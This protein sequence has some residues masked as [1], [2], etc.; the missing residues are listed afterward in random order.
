MI[1]FVIGRNKP[2]KVQIGTLDVNIKLQY[3]IVDY[4]MSIQKNNPDNPGIY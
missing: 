3:M 2:C 1:V 4:I